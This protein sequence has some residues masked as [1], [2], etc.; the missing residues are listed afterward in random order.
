M[1]CLKIADLSHFLEVLRKRDVIES[2]LLNTPTG[3]LKFNHY[4]VQYGVDPMIQ[5]GLISKCG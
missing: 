4:L 5:F 2:N 3:G 1:F